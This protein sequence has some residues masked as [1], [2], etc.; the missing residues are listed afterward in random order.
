MTGLTILTASP[1]A[2]QDEAIY[3]APSGN[4]GLGLNTPLRQLHLR[5]SNAVFRMDR[6]VDTA[7]FLMVRTT[8]EGV[9]LKTFVVGTNAYGANNGQFLINDLGSAVAGAGVR[10]M[11]ITNTGN[12]V[13][14]GTVQAANFVTPSSRQLKENIEKIPNS[15]TLTKQLQGVRFDWKGSGNPALGFIAEDVDSVLPEV[16]E[17]DEESGKVLGVNY[18]AIVPVLVE[19]IKEQQEQIEYCQ[20]RMLEQHNE[21]LSIREEMGQ[22]GSLQAELVSLKLQLSGFQEVNKRLAELTEHAATSQSKTVLLNN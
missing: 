17:H 20:T 14:S 22:I 1:A 12:V 4:V 9:P 19:A 10:R 21:L 6:S 7:A 18:A 11:T 16:V 5:G 3:V 15:L 2:A 13:F 8:P